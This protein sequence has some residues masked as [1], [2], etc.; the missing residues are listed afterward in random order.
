MIESSPNPI[1]AID[2]A[3][4][5]AV[6]RD[7]GLDHVVGDRGGDQQ[8]DPAAQDAPGAARSGRWSAGRG[9]RRAARVGGAV[10][11]AQRDGVA[12]RGQQRLG[13]AQQVDQ[14]GAGQEVEDWRPSV[15]KST[16]RQSRRQARCLDTV[17]CARPSSAGQVD[18]PRLALGEPRHDRQPRGIA[19]RPE[20]RHG[21]SGVRLRSNSSPRSDVSAAW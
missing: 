13:A 14:L 7:D 3:T 17:D 2:D 15:R 18:H 1:S 6:D 12:G 4:V 20:Q 16:S 9:H 21:R 11:G 10:D 8:P 19:Q 5:P